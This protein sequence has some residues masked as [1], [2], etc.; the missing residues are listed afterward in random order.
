[1]IEIINTLGINDF[2][3]VKKLYN[4]LFPLKQIIKV[5]PLQLVLIEN[6][7]YCEVRS[8]LY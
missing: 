1:M 2:M 7:L 3:I 6:A 5:P 4:T 8:L